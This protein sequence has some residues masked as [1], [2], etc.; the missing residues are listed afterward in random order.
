MSFIESHY[1]EVVNKKLAIKMINNITL[2]K[3]HGIIHF[4]EIMN[5]GLFESRAERYDFHTKIL[6][7]SG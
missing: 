4:K 2:E 7:Y 5:L 6:S 1:F 3:R